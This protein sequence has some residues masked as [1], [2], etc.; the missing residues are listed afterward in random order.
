MNRTTLYIIITIIL[1]LILND[2][3]LKVFANAF[4]L[5]FWVSEII[6]AVIVVIIMIIIVKI[7]NR[8]IF[9]NK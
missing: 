7:L 9:K 3:I 8:T 6:I 1:F 2:P 5:N 4:N